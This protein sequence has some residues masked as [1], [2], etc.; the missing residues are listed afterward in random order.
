MLAVLAGVCILALLVWLAVSWRRAR[1]QQAFWAM[2]VGLCFAV[3]SAADSASP[4]CYTAQSGAQ[5]QQQASAFPCR[6][7]GLRL[8]LLS[9][10]EVVAHAGAPHNGPAERAALPHD[11]AVCMK[12]RTA[13]KTSDA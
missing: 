10:N 9:S 8:R 2:Q 4:T 6:P 1:R 5:Q 11:I 7:L 3:V 13:C 12:D